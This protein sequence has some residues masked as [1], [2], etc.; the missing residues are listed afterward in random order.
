MMS[1]LNNMKAIKSAPALVPTMDV[2][3]SGLGLWLVRCWSLSLP[4]DQHPA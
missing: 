3:G 4:E 1:R 2:K